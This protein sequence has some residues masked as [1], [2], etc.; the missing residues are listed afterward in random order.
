[1]KTSNA[2]KV[3]SVLVSVAMCPMMLPTA[4]FAAE[5]DATSSAP[6]SVEQAQ[7]ADQ[8]AGPSSDTLAAQPKAAGNTTDATASEET[9]A[10]ATTTEKAEATEDKAPTPAAK[11]GKESNE[12]AVAEVNGTTYSSLQDA[13]N[14]ASRN[15]TVK[16]LA[17]TK[18]N[19][20][21]STPYVTLDLNGHTLNGGTEK[22]KPALTV[23]NRVYVMDSSEAQTGTIMREDTAEN[24]GVSSHYVIDVQGGNSGWLF[25]QSGNVRNDSGAGGTKG[26]SLVRVGDDSKPGVP[27]LTISG[28]TFTQDNFIVLKCDHG[29]LYVKG[30]TVNSANSYAIENWKNATIK[31]NAV[32]N[33]NVST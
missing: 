11:T 9:S 15:A 17:D 26:A 3:I 22:G 28:G 14:G 21:I 4:A 23:T 31:D 33:G 1:M 6:S 29:N 2:N 18:E 12:A 20:T 5:N 19:V 8:G 10:P 32:I 16:L 25:F 7:P 27:G 24:S 30:G 13:I